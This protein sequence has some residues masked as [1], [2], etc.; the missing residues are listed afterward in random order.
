M[1]GKIE[2]WSTCSLTLDPFKAPEQ[3]FLCIQGQIMDPDRGTMKSIRTSTVVDVKGRK[4]TTRSG[5]VYALGKI[6]PNFRAWL[7]VNRP[8]WN[9]KKPIRMLEDAVRDLPVRQ[10]IDDALEAERF[11]SLDELEEHAQKQRKGK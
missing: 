5:S 1:K 9:W 11:F 2:N 8:A 7:K 3:G 10:L 6:D 4:I